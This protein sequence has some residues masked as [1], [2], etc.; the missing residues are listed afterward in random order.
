MNHPFANLVAFQLCWL[1]AVMGAAAGMPYV[2]PAFA[3]V[4][5][6]LHIFAIRSSAAVELKL[7]LVAGALGYVLDSVLVLAGWLSF[8]SQAQLGAPSS[9]WMVSLWLGFAATL[10]HVLGWLRGRYLL[11]AILGMIFGPLAYWGG[12]RLGAIVLGDGATSLVAIG[13]EWLIAMPLLLGL[14]TVLERNAAAAGRDGVVVARQE[15]W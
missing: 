14:V 10:R 12:S 5:L 2:G 13:V 1:V 4:W 15:N 9:V 11:G 6:A 3:A 7:V 8:P